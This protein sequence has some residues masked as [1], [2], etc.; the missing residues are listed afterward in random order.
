VRRARLGRKIRLIAGAMVICLATLAA[1]APTLFTGSDPLRMHPDS[2]FAP[3]GPHHLLGTDEFGRD[4]FARL[5]YGARPSLAVALGSVLLAGVIGTWVGVASGYLAGLWE[6]VSMRTLEVILCFPPVLLAM[7]VVG[8]LGPGIVHLILVIGF[9][10]IPHFGRFAFGQTVAV[11][12]CEFVEAA[13]AAGASTRRILWRTILPNIIGSL[14][15]QGSLL[16]ASA[17]LLE[18]GL[19]FLG[20]GVVPP[21]PSWGLM[22][23]AA[24]K[25]MF[26]SPTYA[27]WPSLTL[28]VV[29]LSVNTL[30][31]ALVDYWDP[32][33]RTV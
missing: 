1:V 18:S 20:L 15:I 3:P 27:L 5:V 29:I 31:D 22:L 9:L 23:A 33:R 2:A 11:R 25:Y 24:R 17:M 16:V 26:Q 12:R 32:S 7:F 30:S 28:V 21:T 8:F 19:S 14:V 6:L 4:L 10:Y 13:Y